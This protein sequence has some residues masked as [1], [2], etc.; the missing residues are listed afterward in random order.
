MFLQSCN[1]RRLVACDYYRNIM[2]PNKEQ[3]KED[4]VTDTSAKS[5]LS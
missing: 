2:L 5:W 4:M 1:G 3:N